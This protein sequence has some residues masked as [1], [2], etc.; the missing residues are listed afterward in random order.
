[1]KFILQSTLFLLIALKSLPI[2]ARVVGADSLMPKHASNMYTVTAMEP[3]FCFITV[4]LRQQ[5]SGKTHNWEQY[6]VN[7]KLQQGYRIT[8]LIGWQKNNHWGFETGIGISRKEMMVDFPGSLLIPKVSEVNKSNNIMYYH[9]FFNA[10]D[11]PIR[12]VFTAG[13][14]RLKFFSYAGINQTICYNIYQEEI[15]L[16][17]N[18]RISKTLVTKNLD[19]KTIFTSSDW[20][21]GMKYILNKSTQIRF[22]AAVQRSYASVKAT[23]K[24]VLLWGSGL[25]LGYIYTW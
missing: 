13:K 14:G 24:K 7:Q 10:I 5:E 2:N 11:I 19:Y 17:N 21:A 3:E 20:G 25:S 18:N 22:H 1:M 23:N 9:T 4:K 15:E 12:A 8:Q 6:Y 16:V